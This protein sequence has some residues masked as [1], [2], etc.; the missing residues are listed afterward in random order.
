MNRL[1]ALC[2]GAM[3]VATVAIAEPSAAQR[4]GSDSAIRQAIIRQSIAAYPGSCA[5]PYSVARN[6]SRCGARSA[7]SR[8]G[9]YAP[10]CYA[11]DVTDAQVNAYRRNG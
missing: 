2:F 10:V 7:Y 1:R 8:G 11:S 6:G 9:G 5:C 4:G 3:V